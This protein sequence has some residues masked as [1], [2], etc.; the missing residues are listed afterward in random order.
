LSRI[1]AIPQDEQ[2]EDWGC[3]WD[4]PCLPNCGSPVLLDL[5]R[6]GF[7][8]AGLDDGVRFDIDADGDSENVAW[9]KP[10]ESDGFLCFDRNGNGA[11]DDGEELFG[12][13]TPFLLSDGVAPHGYSALAEFDTATLGGNGDGRLTAEDR[14]FNALHVWMDTNHNG[15]SDPGE[16]RP[17]SASG[18][19]RID[20]GDVRRTPRRDSHG[21]WFALV[22]D[23]WLLEDGLIQR[24]R[25]TDVYFVIDGVD[26]ASR[27]FGAK[28][29][30]DG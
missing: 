10:T 8:L 25:A 11:I 27:A 28:G 15:V 23:I 13:A 7:N 4:T 6:N 30:G 18:V 16:V 3:D 17:L 14:A 29:G 5:D 20:L 21:N 1:V 26:E 12:D 19:I 22:G 24:S 2:C 9:T